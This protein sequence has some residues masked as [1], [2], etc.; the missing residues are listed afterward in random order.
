VK[1]LILRGKKDHHAIEG[2]SAPECRSRQAFKEE[3]QSLKKGFGIKKI[4][5]SSTSLRLRIF[6]G[7]TADTRGSDVA[8]SE[9]LSNSSKAG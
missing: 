2:T 3:H 7:K 5:G 9:N 6:H 1:K 4:C 8:T